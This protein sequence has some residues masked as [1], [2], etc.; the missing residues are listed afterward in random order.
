VNWAE[1]CAA[2]IPC[3]NE[4]ARIEK[5]VREVRKFLPAVILV[6]DASSDD[7]GKLAAGAGAEVLRLGNT[8]SGKGA[9][10]RRGWE[11][12]RQRG[13]AWVLCLDGDG[14][15]APGD[16]PVFFE[17]AAQT[18]AD[19]VVGN[20]MAQPAGMPLVRRWTNQ[21]MSW[22]LSRLAGQRLLDTQCGFRLINLAA[23]GQ[24][25]LRTSHFEIDSETLLAFAEAGRKIAFVPIQ[26]I[27]R[28]E[29]SRIRPWRDA[30]RWFAWLRRRG[31]SEQASQ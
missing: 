24:V 27:Y 17:C 26:V 20:R 23:L 22:R 13:F 18:G 19:L 25:N 15:H 7:T 6:D 1:G 12:A 2:I 21:F 14:Q 29:E 9:A 5:V 11:L 30:W 3:L 8:P 16:I 10:L 28:D 4:A 31:Q